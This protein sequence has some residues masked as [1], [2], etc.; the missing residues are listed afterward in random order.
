MMVNSHLKIQQTEAIVGLE[1]LQAAPRH[2][3]AVAWGSPASRGPRARKDCAA[4]GAGRQAPSGGGS[5][6]APPSGLK[7][8]RRSPSHESR[9][10]GPAPGSATVVGRRHGDRGERTPTEPRRHCPG[11]LPRGLPPTHSRAPPHLWA[12][13]GPLSPSV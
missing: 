7:E 6:T 4:G 11:P 8:E 1:G 9:D 10:K 12:L 13:H 5:A 2:S 3:S